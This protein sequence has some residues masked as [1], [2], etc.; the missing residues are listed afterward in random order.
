MR[1]SNPRLR[2]LKS[3]D[4]PFGLLSRC[5]VQGNRGILGGKTHSR[6]ASRAAELGRTF[7]VQLRVAGAR[8]AFRKIGFFTE[9]RMQSAI[10]CTH[11]HEYACCATALALR[12]VP[13][14][15]AT[16]SRHGYFRATRSRH[17]FALR[18]STRSR[19]ELCRYAESLRLAATYGLRG[20]STGCRCRHRQP[21]Q[22]LQPRQPVGGRVR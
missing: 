8:S 14:F 9:A 1:D 11:I 7:P 19:S 22:V 12:A 2:D 3:D 16:R 17:G 4:L 18:A 20:G 5:R 21:G 10:K 6:T 15:R 13:R